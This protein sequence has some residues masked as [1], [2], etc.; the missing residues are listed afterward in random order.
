MS[1]R[2]LAMLYISLENGL[3][4]VNN[5]RN[6]LAMFYGLRVKMSA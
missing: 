5:V 4:E 6:R 2:N 1:Q 3:I